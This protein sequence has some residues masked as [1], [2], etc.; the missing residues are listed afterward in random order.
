MYSVLLCFCLVH[1]ILMKFQIL[2]HRYKF[3]LMFSILAMM[4]CIFKINIYDISQ[5]IKKKNTNKMRSNEY[6]L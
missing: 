4:T 6:T 2:R 5:L 3:T 1:N